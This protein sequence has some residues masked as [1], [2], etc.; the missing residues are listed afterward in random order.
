MANNQPYARRIVQLLVGTYMLVYLGLID[1][2]N[3]QI[4]GFWYY[5]FTGVFEAATIHYAVA[6]IFGSTDILEEA[7]VEF[8]CWTAMIH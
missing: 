3:M 5:L 8:A 4:E 2:E 7:G 1:N 6:K